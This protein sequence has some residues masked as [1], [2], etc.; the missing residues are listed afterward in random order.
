MTRRSLP[1]SRADKQRRVA[2]F[3]FSPANVAY[4]RNYMAEGG[5]S[6]PAAM[7]EGLTPEQAAV[8]RAPFAGR[9]DR[10]ELSIDKQGQVTPTKF[11]RA[12]EKKNFD[13]AVLGDKTIGL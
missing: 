12:A 3:R 5:A 7:Y 11:E 9:L 8:L 4:G 10:V 2:L 6:W 1:W 13:K